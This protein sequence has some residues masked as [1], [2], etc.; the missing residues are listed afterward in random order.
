MELIKSIKVGITAVM[1]C[2]SAWL[3]ALYLPVLL[4]VSCNVID[5]ITGMMAAPYRTTVIDSDIGIKG[6]IKKVMMWLLVGV[7]AIMDSLL[8][9]ASETIGY[10]LPFHYLIACV[11]A[12][13]IICNELISILE[14]ITDAGVP[15]PPF[16]QP[17]IE[18]LKNQTESKLNTESEE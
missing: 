3:G 13:W 6:I 7:G 2:A 11:V 4:L 8:T 18:N 5:Y 14:N 12:I 9:Y 15:T 17:L 10:E 16:L 1:A